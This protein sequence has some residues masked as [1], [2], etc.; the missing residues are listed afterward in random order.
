MD[1]TLRVLHLEHIAGLLVGDE[2]VRQSR[3]V[4]SVGLAHAVVSH[5]CMCSFILK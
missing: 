3:A 5:R 4:S 2:E 1:E